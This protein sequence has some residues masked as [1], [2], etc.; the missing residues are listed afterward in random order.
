MSSSRPSRVPSI[1]SR[2]FGYLLLPLVLLL[3]ASIWADHRTYVS[4]MYDMFDRALSHSAVAIASHV[5]KGPDGHLYVE[6]QDPGPPLIHGPGE[7]PMPLPPPPGDEPFERGRPPGRFDP[8]YRPMSWMRLYSGAHENFVYRVSQ[9]DGTT[10]AGDETLPMTTGE[11]IDNLTYGE[12][13]HKGLYYRLASYHTVV[14]GEP[15]VVTVGETVHR[16][17]TIVRRLD[18]LVGVSD[19]IQ[20]LLV[21]GLC[22]FG[23]RIALRP[24]N[25]LRD[26]IMQRE[27]Q[28]LQPLPLDPIPSEVRPLVQSM[29]TLFVTVRDSTL[30]QQHFLTNAAH[31][32]RTPLTGL[33]A[34]LEVLANETQDRAQQERISRL[35][36]SV[37]RLAHTANQLLALAR[38]EP[39]AHGP[40]DFVAIQLDALISAVVGSM[41]DRALTHD[42]DLGAECEP[43]QVH[44][45]YWLLHE[46]LIN[47][48]DNAIRHT[49]KQGNITLRCGRHNGAPYLE[50]EDSGPGIPA[51]ERERVRER[52]YRAAGSD[53][54]SSGLGLAIVEEI[55]RSHRARFQILDAHEG[56]GA[57]MRIEFPP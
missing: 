13:R 9:A 55:A 4:P 15:I 8:E 14:D 29:N 17:D 25:R 42:I 21:L 41:L 57:R 26:Q 36:G 7:G 54:Q 24:I 34:Q 19:G 35:Q 46:L 51:A 43:V 18:T 20:L 2:L 30:A 10:L 31:Q 33:K 11:I 47:L 38:A 27:P 3:I 1:R 37:D 44:G 22:L 49:P 45:V 23:I 50:V 52:F 12:T 48:V 40:S 32:L 6:K 56:T 16:R 28:S 39:S 5:H 53:G